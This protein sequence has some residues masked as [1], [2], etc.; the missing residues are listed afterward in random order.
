MV[1]SFVKGQ[2]AK[3]FAAEEGS[4]VYDLLDGLGCIRQSGCGFLSNFKPFE[5]CN[6]R[7]EV[8]HCNDTGYLS[9]L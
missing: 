8:M 2:G 9:F 6:D 4:R 1:L 3:R 5:D 7:P